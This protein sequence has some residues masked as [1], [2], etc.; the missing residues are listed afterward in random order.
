M[1]LSYIYQEIELFVESLPEIF[2]DVEVNFPFKNN[3]TSIGDWSD[4]A[5][6]GMVVTGD[7]IGNKRG[8]YFFAK[9]NGTVFYI[10][11]AAD[12]SLHDRVWDHVNTPRHV[13]ETVKEY[14]NQKFRCES[15]K[16]EIESVIS[17]KA[18]LGVATLSDPDVAALVEVFL[19][20]IHKKKFGKLPAI[21][22]RIG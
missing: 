4:S 19:H 5:K 8:I 16:E 10:G 18:L 12:S 20:T 3:G 7:G 6:M 1:K 9:P 15:A 2:N 22:K 14:P 21:N 11:K 17:G 13:S